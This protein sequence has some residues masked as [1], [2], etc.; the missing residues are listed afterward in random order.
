M[1]KTYLTLAIR[2]KTLL[3]RAKAVGAEV[4]TW[5]AIED[6]LLPK[7]VI[8]SHPHAGGFMW[9]FRFRASDCPARIVHGS[10]SSNDI[11][12]LFM[13]QQ[14]IFALYEHMHEKADVDA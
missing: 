11:A 8:F 9:E 3:E 5:Q 10:A 12:H 7:G 13:L 1:D 4:K 6:F 14:A 2:D